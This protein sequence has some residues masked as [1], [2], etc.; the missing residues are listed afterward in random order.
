MTQRF[1]RLFK[2]DKDGHWCKG[3]CWYGRQFTKHKCVSVGQQFNKY[4]TLSR[5]AENAAIA[6]DNSSSDDKVTYLMDWGKIT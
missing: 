4:M 6:A 5:D 3:S 1:H 2:H